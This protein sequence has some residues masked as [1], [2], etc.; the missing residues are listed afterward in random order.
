MTRVAIYARYSSVLQKATSIED[1]L[2]LCREHANKMGW[3]IVAE[4]TEFESSAF[5]GSMHTRT[6][7]HDLLAGVR[8]HKFDV[9]LAEAWDR[10]ARSLEDGANMFN[11]AD[12]AGVKFFTL[13]E[14][15]INILHVAI[16]GLSAQTYVTDMR[17]KVKRGQRGRVENGKMGG[18]N[19]Y[20][21]DVVKRLD[22]RGKKVHG[23]RTINTVQAKIVER[24]F[25]EYAVGESPKAIATGLNADGIPRPAGRGWGPST[26]Y[27]N[28]QRGAGILN[29]ELYIGQIVWNK[30]SYPKNPDTGLHVT[31]INPEAEWVRKEVP[32]LRIIDQDLWARVKARQKRSRVSAKKFWEHQRPRLLFSY[33]LKCG[34]CGGGCS[35]ISRLQYG[36]TTARNKGIS[37]CR[38][39]RVIKQDVLECTV[40]DILQKRLMDPKLVEVFCAEYQTHMNRLRMQRNASVTAYKSELEKAKRRERR[41]V[42]AVMEGYGNEALKQESIAVENRRKE[43]EQLL[44]DQK[45]EPVLLHPRMA[46]R[47]HKEVSNLLGALNDPTLRREA[48]DLVR[49]LIEKIV[50]TPNP[51]SEGLVV[52]L[53]GD[54]AG[55]L[56]IATGQ[57]DAKAKEEIDLKQ[58]R[59]VVGLDSTPSPVRQGKM[60]G[61]AALRFS[62]QSANPTEKQPKGKTAIR[63]F[64]SLPIMQDKL[65]GP[66][67]FEPPTRPL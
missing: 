64:A 2:R 25:R 43:L 60:V 28:W 17:N 32:E 20:G 34:Y 55:I 65:V 6:A 57:S 46:E 39:M 40:V 7:I 63:R 24:I 30:V 31:R 56:N 53:Y 4:F 35:K 62:Q 49:S 22:E 44:A 27:G 10:I 18:G 66:G 23:E 9:V 50:L 38:N 37:L 5:I 13:T 11:R 67:G 45:E 36:C 41:I 48:G 47:Y 12:F 19:C 14:G 54:L 51:K 8:A 16:K 15:E 33:L 26:I 58:I 1:Q 3:K 61:T 52:D 21:Y 29:N 42:E 59:L